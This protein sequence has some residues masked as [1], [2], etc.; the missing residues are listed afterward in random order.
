MLNALQN[1]L[2]EMPERR[3][4]V[5]LVV[6]SPWDE[7]PT[8]MLFNATLHS[9]DQLGVAYLPLDE[10]GEEYLVTVPWASVLKVVVLHPVLRLH[11]ELA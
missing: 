3:L 6:L 11:D 4:R 2:N 8:K 7:E 10:T 5:N 1:Q 9:V